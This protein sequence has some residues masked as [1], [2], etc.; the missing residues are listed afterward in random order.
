M[1]GCLERGGTEAFIMN[2][3]RNIDRSQIQFDFLVL[4]KKDYPYLEEIKELGGNVYFGVPFRKRHIGAFMKRCISVMKQTPY[5]AV[6]SHLNLLNG[7]ILLAA[8]YAGISKRISHSHDTYG[9]DGRFY[10][11]L[12]HKAE[13]F[14][15]RSCGTE[16]LACS[17]DAGNYLYGEKL[18]L[19][20]GNVI[21][22]GIDVEMFLKASETPD[23]LNIPPETTLVIGNISRFEAKK[24]QLFLLDVFEEI[25]VSE[26]N[27]ILL[28]GGVDGGQ[29]DQCRKK[30]KNLD[31]TDKVCFIGIR[32]D[33]PK[34]LR[35]LDI[36]IFPSLYEGLGIVLLEAQAAGCYC[37]ASTECPC[38]SDM[39]LGRI[40]YIPLE[41]DCKLW[42]K[43]ILQG[44]AEAKDYPSFQE[45]RNAF[46]RKNYSV[47]WLSKKM[48]DIYIGKS[49]NEAK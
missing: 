38:D 26:P 2:L 18:F 22:N 43:R 30:V 5:V 31:I 16:F 42:A 39:G 8:K 25:L 37:V 45:V 3:Y 44:Y 4:H 9:K 12:M 17:A 24:N 32:E 46:D 36:Y 6:H 10:E 23:D 7:W 15:I 29:L 21:N 14:F 47:S 49:L 28:L 41:N 34:V 11:R 48:A 13:C 27:A 35:M 19:K 20:K 1:V 40:D 33:M